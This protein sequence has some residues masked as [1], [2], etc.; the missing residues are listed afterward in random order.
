MRAILPVR[1]W[2]WELVSENSGVSIFME[3]SIFF[4]YFIM[5][6][7]PPPQ[8]SHPRNRMVRKSFF[9]KPIRRLKPIEGLRRR[10]MNV[11]GLEKSSL[12][13]TKMTQ[14]MRI[15]TKHTK[16]GMFGMR[17][18]RYRYTEKIIP[19]LS[20]YR[21]SFDNYKG[22]FFNGTLKEILSN[23]KREN[24]NFEA[25]SNDMHVLSVKSHWS[26]NSK[27]LALQ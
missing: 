8:A 22:K 20:V 14:A 18:F 13:I 3:C 17:N 12:K 1:M 4:Q 23:S 26:G 24:D 19:I 16:V 2:V 15:T 25:V 6:V 11:M 10:V 21:F 27:S 5:N 9:S 7:Y